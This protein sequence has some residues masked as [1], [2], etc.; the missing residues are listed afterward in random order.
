MPARRQIWAGG[1][2]KASQRRR[3]ASWWAKWTPEWERALWAQGA[4]YSGVPRARR[5][6]RTGTASLARAGDTGAGPCRTK[7]GLSTPT[8]S[9]G[10]VLRPPWSANTSVLQRGPAT[11]LIGPGLWRPRPEGPCSPVLGWTGRDTQGSL[12]R[13]VQLG[14]SQ[15]SSHFSTV[16][17]GGC[18]TQ[19]RALAET[20]TGTERLVKA[21]DAGQR[22]A[23]SRPK[24]RA[25]R[26]KSRPQVRGVQ[27]WTQRGSGVP[28]LA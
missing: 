2:G 15:S 8:R 19:P 6:R 4:G 17:A 25:W 21:E 12:G 20:C 16:T 26:R 11:L 22:G 18:V 27:A 23:V 5:A 10:S 9:L 14:P 7:R 1:T 3:P 28:V 24:P 13:C